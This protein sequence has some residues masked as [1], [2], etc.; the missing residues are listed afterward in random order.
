MLTLL[1]LKVTALMNGCDVIY[2][3][4]IQKKTNSRSSNNG[5]GTY[6]YSTWKAT[7]TATKLRKGR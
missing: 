3:Y 2:D 1:Q 4:R 6:Y 7:G 5:D